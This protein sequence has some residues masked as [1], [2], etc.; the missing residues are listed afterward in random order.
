[1]AEIHDSIVLTCQR[2]GGPIERQQLELMIADVADIMTRPFIGILDDDPYF[3]VKV[4]IGDRW[5]QWRVDRVYR[6]TGV[7]RLSD[8]NVEQESGGEEATAQQEKA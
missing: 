2:P 6:E 4:S 3:P 5:R 7:E 8:D 1:M